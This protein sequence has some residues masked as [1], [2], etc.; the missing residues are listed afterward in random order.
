MIGI[1]FGVWTSQGASSARQSKPASSNS[2]RLAGSSE[3][4]AATAAPAEPPPTTMT[5]YIALLLDVPGIGIADAIKAAQVGGCNPAPGDDLTSSQCTQPLSAVTTT[6]IKAPPPR[7]APPTA[8][9]AGRLS[10]NQSDQSESI[11]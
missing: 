1:G 3:S 6:S 5:S 2:T 4:R 11:T 7:S 9:R 8:A 10:P